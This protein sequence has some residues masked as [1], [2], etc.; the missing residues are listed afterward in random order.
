MIYVDVV[1]FIG[2]LH[3]IYVFET[4]LIVYRYI[5]NMVLY[6]YLYIAN[7]IHCLVGA[8]VCL[9][10]GLFVYY[11]KTNLHQLNAV[12]QF[13]II[14]CGNSVDGNGDQFN[15]F[16]IILL[17]FLPNNL[18]VLCLSSFSSFTSPKI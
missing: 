6:K 12:V 18:F 16:S 11:I 10:V 17:Y 8:Y 9:F 1:A 3:V 4:I 7:T 14:I 2:S 13:D 15:Y 5:Y